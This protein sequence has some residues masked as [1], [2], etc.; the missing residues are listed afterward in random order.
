[1][2]NQVLNRL[3]NLANLLFFLSKYHYWYDV[4][5]YHKFVLKSQL[6]P[7]KSQIDVAR[8]QNY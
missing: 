8:L 4:L 7:K 6:P 5:I 1:M 2:K 3:S